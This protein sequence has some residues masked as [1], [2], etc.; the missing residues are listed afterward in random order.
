VKLREDVHRYREVNGV[1]II[2]MLC[3]KAIN[4]LRLNG[5]WSVTEG[6]SGKPSQIA[7]K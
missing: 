4:A 2:A 6:D 5:I 7:R 1:Q 3:T